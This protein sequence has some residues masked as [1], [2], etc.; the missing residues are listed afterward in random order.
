MYRRFFFLLCSL[1]YCWIT[2]PATAGEVNLEA[3]VSLIK[4]YD[5]V[6]PGLGGTWRPNFLRYQRFSLGLGCVAS[7][8]DRFYY[9]RTPALPVPENMTPDTLATWMYVNDNH[10]EAITLDFQ[11][12]RARATISTI[13]GSPSGKAG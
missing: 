10:M 12:K 5:K 8:S 3:N 2:V 13:G 9:E 7:V 11:M 4:P 1:L 6:I